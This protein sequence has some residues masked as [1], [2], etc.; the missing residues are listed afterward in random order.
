MSSAECGAVETELSPFLEQPVIEAAQGVAIA[1]PW[2]AGRIR[3][4]E[5][6]LD[7]RLIGAAELVF[8][9]V[10][11]DP[12]PRHGPAKRHLRRRA[13]E[14]RQHVAVATAERSVGQTERS[15][16]MMSTMNVGRVC[17][18]VDGMRQVVRR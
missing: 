1:A 3:R 9:E 12:S 5:L 6:G 13:S 7:A 14:R 2:Q 4:S 16:A 15:G 17:R 18:R 8:A 11:A 10:I